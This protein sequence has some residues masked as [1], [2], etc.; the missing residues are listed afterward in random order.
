MADAAP[1]SLWYSWRHRLLTALLIVTVF[2]RPL[3][4][5]GFATG[6]LS[7]L[8]GGLVLLTFATVCWGRRA[9]LIGGALLVLT[10]AVA[11]ALPFAWDLLSDGARRFVAG[12]SLVLAVAYL[13]FICGMILREVLQGLEVTLDNVFGA[14]CVYLISGVIWADVYLLVFLIDPTAFKIDGTNMLIIADAPATIYAYM[15]IFDY[16][17]FS[18]LTALGF[19]DILPVSPLTRTMAWMEAATGLLYVAVILARLVCL[20]TARLMSEKQSAHDQSEK[21]S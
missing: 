19:G 18:T 3:V 20:E 4:V 16:F 1:N 12:G 11:M 13:G 21:H 15:G 10:L 5:S 7:E 6:M 14:V 2:V 8:F 17:S 9:L